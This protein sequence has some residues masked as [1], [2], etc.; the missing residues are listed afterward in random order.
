[1]VSENVVRCPRC[2]YEYHSWVEVCPDCGTPL[3]A[4]PQLQLIKG[5]VDPGGDPRWSVVTNVPNAIMGNF[6]KSLIEDAGIPV[7]MRRSSSADIAEF[8][9]NDFVPH[10]LL[11]PFHQLRVARSLV[12]SPPGD[13][14]DPYNSFGAYDTEYS[15]DSNNYSEYGQESEPSQQTGITDEGYG[16][17]PE[18]PDGWM[19][20]PTEADL[21][22]LQQFRRSKGEPS[23][24]WRWAGH[25][26][27]GEP[28]VSDY[29]PV[30][31]VPDLG[32][33][34]RNVFRPAPSRYGQR[35]YGDR[36]GGTPKW[37][38]IVYGVMLATMSLPFLARMLGD[39][40]SALG[41]R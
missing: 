13:N 30:P 38:R 11:V 1:M 32:S 24:E 27:N 19:M 28:P 17:R 15:S 10:E 4:R 26:P 39:V 40:L 34:E 3:E 2:G 8:S 9:H 35:D 18:L 22:S 7:L 29:A 21:H 6:L 23:D 25:Q 41:Q 36:W 14:F 5:N 16:P 12:D 33:Y 20:L 31:S 37:V